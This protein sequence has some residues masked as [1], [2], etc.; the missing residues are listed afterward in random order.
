MEMVTKHI[1]IKKEVEQL[2][3]NSDKFF[4]SGAFPIVSSILESHELRIHIKR[5]RT[6]KYGDFNPPN[7]ISRIPVITINNDLNPY[8]F[9]ITLLHEFAHY[10]VWKDGHHYAKPHGRTWK[11]HF[12]NLIQIMINENI[13]PESLLPSISR[14]IQNP[15][16][17]SCTDIKLFRELSNF[18]TDQ[19]GVFVE[20][21]NDGALFQTKDGQIYC[22]QKKVRKRILCTRLKKNK[23]YLFSPIFRVFPV[24]E[25]SIIKQFSSN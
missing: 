17:T 18:D 6:T 20:D 16:A 11:N 12:S 5:K 21:I 4:P 8:S 23:Q 19:I 22:R 25:Q 14:H 10:L 13:F 24:N 9:L 7:K 1:I 3:R 2:N 15:R